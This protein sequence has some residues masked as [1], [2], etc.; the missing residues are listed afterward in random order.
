MRGFTS[1]LVLTA[2]LFAVSASAQQ[3]P[4][5]SMSVLN[6][7]HFNPASSVFS[8]R[9]DIVGVHRDQWNNIPGG[10]STQLISGHFPFDFGLSAVGFEFVNDAIGLER[11]MSL[12]L[13]YSQRL[14]T[15]YGDIGIGVRAGGEQKSL[16]QSRLRTPGGNYGESTIEHNDPLL[17][18]QNLSSIVPVFGLSVWYRSYLGFEAGISV[19]QIPGGKHFGGENFD[20]ETKPVY[21]VYGEY[22][23]PVLEDWYIIPSGH[24]YTDFTQTQVYLHALGSYQ[25]IYF[26]GLGLRGITPNSLDAITLMAGIRINDRF[27][28]YYNYDIGLSGLYRPSNQTHEFSVVYRGG[29]WTHRRQ[30]PP[31]IY[32]PRF[33][34]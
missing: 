28:A 29:E 9:L 5:F 7:Y 33:L 31:V 6:K 34:E 8:D 11:Q 27:T 10:P 4:H 1:G 22:Y 20:F 23:V 12:S 32:N 15:A 26:G 25:N 18:G 19:N 17:D 21:S 30:K 14:N 3:T 24:L 13:S 16:D 2:L